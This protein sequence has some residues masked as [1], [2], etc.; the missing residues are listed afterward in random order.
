MTIR[1]RFLSLDRN[2]D[3]RL[4]LRTLG[5]PGGAVEFLAGSLPQGHLLVSGLEAPCATLVRRLVAEV[6]GMPR[7]LEGIRSGAILV[8]GRLSEIK[9]LGLK[10]QARLDVDQAPMAGGLIQ[11]AC[12]HAGRMEPVEIG[13]LKAG[14]GR[15]LVMGILNVTPDS[16]SD[17]GRFL[18]PKAALSRAMALVEAGADLL[19]V[20]GESTRPKGLYGEG[21]R[22]LTAAEERSRVEPVVRLLASELPGVAISVDTSSAEVA[23]AAIGAGA[24]MINDVRGLRDDALADV[25]RRNRVAA[26]VMHMPAEPGEMAEHTSYEDV[27]GQVGEALCDLVDHAEARGVPPGRLLVDP[28]IGFGKTFGQSLFLL[29]QLALLEAAVGRPVMVGTSRKGF[30][31]HVTGRPVEERD[32]ATAASVVAAILGGAAV[33]RVHDVAACRDAVRVADAIALGEEG[34]DFFAAEDDGWT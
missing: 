33:V 4:A 3:L 13:S 11:R 5:F 25:V 6:P 9:Y 19:D 18:D 10:V 7:I 29:R 31:G 2:S 28:G 32:P 15:T 27:V 26:C 20:G 17:G 22:R 1:A 12:F 16:F 34:G 8:S 30:L 21:A 23:E 24:V 14:A